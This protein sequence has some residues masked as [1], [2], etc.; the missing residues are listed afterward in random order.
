MK[1]DTKEINKINEAL[2][3]IEG[4]SV[5]DFKM[6]DKKS[7]THM[8]TIRLKQSKKEKIEEVDDEH[9]GSQ[10]VIDPPGTNGIDINIVRKYD[11]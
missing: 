1:I 2:E 5:E 7:G 6:W 9:F 4:W 10:P 11:D 3:A 8:A